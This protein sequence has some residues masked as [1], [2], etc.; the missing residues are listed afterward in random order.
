MI[1]T[2]REA[3]AG[4]RRKSSRC[5]L[6]ESTQTRVSRRGLTGVPTWFVSLVVVTCD[7]CGH[8]FTVARDVSIRRADSPFHS[9]TPTPNLTQVRESDDGEGRQGATGPSCPN[10]GLSTTQ[11]LPIGPNESFIAHFRLRDRL[12]CRTC[13]AAFE[14]VNLL[15]GA[16]QT[17]ALVAILGATSWGA[18]KLADRRRPAKENNS[19]RV[20]KVPTPPPPVLNR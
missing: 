8:R 4:S 7:A 2:F 16:L 5:P 14:R 20:K 10:C 13:N 11:V 19:P 9:D 6:C 3:W 1:L 12:R 17:V 15:K 18:L